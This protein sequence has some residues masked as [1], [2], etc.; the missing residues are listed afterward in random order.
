V[1]TRM[2]AL[3]QDS[4]AWRQAIFESD[5]LRAVDLHRARRAGSRWSGGAAR[6]RWLGD[7]PQVACWAVRRAPPRSLAGEVPKRQTPLGARVSCLARAVRPGNPP[8][9]P[10]VLPT[11]VGGCFAVPTHP[12]T[13]LQ[14]P[15]HTYLPTWRWRRAP[16]AARNAPRAGLT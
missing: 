8:R 12:P 1:R 9:D 4:S 3:V 10:W 16:L 15:T 7:A 11:W 13:R 14:T 6:W 2:T 5:L